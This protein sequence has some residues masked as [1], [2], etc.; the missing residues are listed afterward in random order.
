MLRHIVSTNWQKQMGNL[1]PFSLCFS[2]PHMKVHSIYYNQVSLSFWLPLRK[3]LKNK[4]LFFFFLS[5]YNSIYFRILSLY[6]FTFLV[7]LC[8]DYY[9][10]YTTY[11]RESPHGILANVLDSDIVVSLNSSCTIT[12]TFRLISLGK[13]WTSSPPQ[14]WVK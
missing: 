10:I 13:V 4:R 12:F 5:H 9:Y 8:T 1:F 2:L 3:K 7:S 14:L 11:L 6:H